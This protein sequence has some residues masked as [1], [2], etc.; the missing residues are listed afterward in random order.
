M[1][2]IRRYRTGIV[3]FGRWAIFRRSGRGV[4]TIYRV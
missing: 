2:P 3:I 4:L 1:T